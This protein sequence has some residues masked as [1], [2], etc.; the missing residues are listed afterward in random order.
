MHIN[1]NDGKYMLEPDDDYADDDDYDLKN[2]KFSRW[3]NKPML[4][5]FF[6]K[7][8]H[9]GSKFYYDYYDYYDYD[10]DD[11]DDDDDDADAPDS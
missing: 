5:V 10:A 3:C 7:K 8:K 9:A 11:D 6:F 2:L 4:H 1:D